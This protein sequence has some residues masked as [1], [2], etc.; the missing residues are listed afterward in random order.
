M[1]RVVSIILIFFAVCLGCAAKDNHLLKFAETS[2]NF[3]A[4]SEDASPVTHQYEFTNTADEPVA[5]LS[6]STECGCTT[7][8][9]PVKP[10]APGE[11]GELVIAGD[12][13][14][15]GY[16]DNPEENDRVFFEMDG[17]RYVR[18]G[19]FGYMDEDGFLYFVQRLKRIIK[20]AGISVYPKE[21]ESSALE[22]PGVTGSCAVEYKDGGKTKIALF[23]TGKAQ[24]ETEV[25]AK[26]EADLSHY[27]VPT[28]VRVIDA[29]PLTPVMKADTIAL[30]AEAERIAKGE[31]S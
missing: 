15:N 28:I 18:T 20:I 10:L 23:L 8:E 4:V 5:I 16:L 17:E 13:L 30:S 22:I 11:K 2:Y 26:I 14:M 27:A 31:I 24:D 21:I 12:T 9:Y 19:D 25:K 1:K 7:P 3:G 29:I 6:V